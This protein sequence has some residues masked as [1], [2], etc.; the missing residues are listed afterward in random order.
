MTLVSLAP[1]SDGVW[2]WNCADALG[3]VR[4]CLATWTQVGIMDVILIE[5]KR[6][7]AVIL[8]LRID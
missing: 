8:I 3:T 4:Y 6:V 7:P 5:G 1:V 2:R